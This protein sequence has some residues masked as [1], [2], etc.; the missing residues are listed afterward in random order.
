MA[1]IPTTGLDV[2][3]LCLGGN[4]FGWT[5]DEQAS[6]AVL[7]AYA[8]AGG[9][10]VDT[11]DVYS[12][13]APGNSGGESERV[14]GAWMRSRGNREQVVVA[15]K[16]AK[17]SA[18][19]GLA[20]ATIAKA[21]DESL[22]RLGTD[23]I[24]LYYAHEDDPSVPVEDVLGAFAELVR[25]GKVRQ[26]AASN[27][28]AGRLAEFL[29]V[30]QREG[31]PR[32]VALQNA[33]NLVNRDEYGAGLQQLVTRERLAF[34]PYYGLASGF[35]TGKYRPG[36]SVD[37]VRSG[38]AAAYLQD[39]R[40]AGLLAA[41]DETAQAHGTSVAAVALAWLRVQPG[42]VA[43]IA[44]ARTPEQLADVLPA[45]TLELSSDELERLTAAWS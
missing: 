22:S 29:A 42:V 11:A 26:V 15:T 40:S 8:A 18:L 13:W 7:D 36:A 12:E 28:S 35:L 30:S 44:S 19:R 24:D 10:F 34:L 17:H 1:T 38:G 20:P 14:L 33:Y 21:A 9:N 27:F 45:A 25:A 16:V 3:G 2:F 32:F 41:L 37:S 39:P 6:F 43:P 31:L 4:V 23:Y 5:A